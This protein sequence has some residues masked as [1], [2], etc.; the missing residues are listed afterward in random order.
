MVSYVTETVRL[1]IVTRSSVALNTR[2]SLHLMGS[3]HPSGMCLR[4][5]DVAFVIPSL[6]GYEVG[7]R[8][9]ASILYLLDTSVGK[10]AVRL[11]S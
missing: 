10:F 8:Y 9:L 6:S 7:R 4:V 5:H 3:L 2:P 1:K 11:S